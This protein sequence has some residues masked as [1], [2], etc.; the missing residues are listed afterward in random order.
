MSVDGSE[1]S[2]SGH[3]VCQHDQMSVIDVN[4]VRFE[5]LFE[6]VQ[7]RLTGSLYSKDIVYLADIVGCCS[8]WIDFRVIQA[9]T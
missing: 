9:E 5:D 4:A 1:E 7:K 8:S 6:F 3:P 2:S